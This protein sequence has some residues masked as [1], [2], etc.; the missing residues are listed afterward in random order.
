MVGSEVSSKSRRSFGPCITEDPPPTD[1][2]GLARY[3]R[4]H[5]RSRLIAEYGRY[6]IV[7][8]SSRAIAAKLPL[9]YL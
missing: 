6:D 8:C 7:F 9:F 1:S 4:Y 5:P 3:H 2:L